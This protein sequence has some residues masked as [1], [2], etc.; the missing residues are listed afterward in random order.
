LSLAIVSPFLVPTTPPP[1]FFSSSPPN[2]SVFDFHLSSTI[3]PSLVFAP[4]RCKEGRKKSK[5]EN[6][7]APLSPPPK[8]NFE[9]R[10]GRPQ[11]QLLAAGGCEIRS[12]RGQPAD[13]WRPGSAVPGQWMD[14]CPDPATRRRG[15]R[16][17]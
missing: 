10:Y 13:R 16:S 14:H 1:F 2:S 4:P 12:V 11:R 17:M 6:K 7:A 3:C 15:I 5:R 8:G 9:D